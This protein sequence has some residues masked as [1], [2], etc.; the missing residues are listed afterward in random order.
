MPSFLER[1]H[2]VS[3]PQFKITRRNNGSQTE[4][5]PYREQ[6]HCIDVRAR[7]EAVRHSCEK[8][9]YATR[10]DERLMTTPPLK[11][12]V[13]PRSNVAGALPNRGDKADNMGHAGS[14]GTPCLY[15]Q[16]FRARDR[17]RE[18]TSVLESYRSNGHDAFIQA[19][20]PESWM[21]FSSQSNRVQPC[22][23]LQKK[24][25]GILA[26]TLKHMAQV[27]SRARGARK[28]CIRSEIQPTGSV[29]TVSAGIEV[30]AVTV[31]LTA[32][33][34]M[35]RP[36]GLRQTDRTDI[37]K[38]TN[39]ADDTRAMAP[40][41]GHHVGQDN[42]YDDKSRCVDRSMVQQRSSYRTVGR[43]DAQRHAGNHGSQRRSRGQKNLAK[44]NRRIMYAY[45]LRGNHG[46][47]L[48]KEKPEIEEYGKA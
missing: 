4:V 47:W 19:N 43:H 14:Y 48:P 24:V 27:I 6:S 34:P 10:H 28:T 16:L 36:G 30:E 5:A 37:D 35:V 11:A 12:V 33:L 18:W 26:V 2:P 9:E 3:A 41:V 13:L 25:H 39:R 17:S 38:A 23:V 31:A 21:T 1:F 20:T 22:A 7:Q 46:P 40:P 44:H 29:C 42:P 8:S 32:S 45:V 15:H